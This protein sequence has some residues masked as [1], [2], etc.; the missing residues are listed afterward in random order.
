M[1]AYFKMKK[2]AIIAIVA[3]VVVVLLGVGGFFI[4]KDMRQEKILIEESFC[5]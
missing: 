3:V 1:I 5:A 4:T 2:N